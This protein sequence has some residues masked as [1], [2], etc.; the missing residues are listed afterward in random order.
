MST[1]YAEPLARINGGLDDLAG[2]APEFRGT[3]EKQELLVGLSRVIARAQAEQLRVL[4]TAD[5]VA[6]ATGDRSTATWLATATRDAPGR[7][8]ADARLAAALDQ[9]WTQVGAALG[10]AAVNLAQARVICEA[11][12]ALPKDLG[13]DLLAKAETLLVT[14]AD[15]LGPRELRTFGSRI[16][17]YLAPDVAEEADYQRLLDQERRAA[18]ATRLTLR[19]RGDGSTD[20]HARIPDLTASLLRTFL[21]AFTAPRRRHQH[22]ETEHRGS[23]RHRDEFAN[24]PIARQQGIGFLALLERVLKS[25]LPRHGGK[26]TS[27][28]VLID[29]DTLLADLTA[30]GIAQTSTGEKMTA[31]QARRLA[32]QASPPAGRDLG[33]R[34]PAQ[35]PRSG[36]GFETGAARP[37]Q[38]AER[39]P[40]PRLE[41]Q[42]PPQ[43]HHH[44]HPTPIA[45]CERRLC[46]HRVSRQALRAFLNQRSSGV[47]LPLPVSSPGFETG[48][49]RL[50]QPAEHRVPPPRP[51][52]LT[53]F[54]DRRCAPSSTNG[55][56]ASS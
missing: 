51:G 22:G 41:H 53:G 38:P 12:E 47:P 28:V 10:C 42:L 25:D 2:I 24:L 56:P 11:L 5:D 44:L 43:R 52:V 32:C 46:T 49:A 4:A 20:L 6:E 27:L 3:G 16:L 15:Q 29:H 13:E 31:G 21:A 19:R 50:P 35:A 9:R 33:P 37:P 18:A 39:H 30:A 26:A 45:W 34:I 1:T 14:E 55:A 36:H 23:S 17:E 40:R 8:R 54:R 7:V 48:P